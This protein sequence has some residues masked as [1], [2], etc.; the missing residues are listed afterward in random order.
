MTTR[1]AFGLVFVTSINFVFGF[2]DIENKLFHKSLTKSI[3]PDV[4]LTTVS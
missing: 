3:N 4:Y 2:F 1:I